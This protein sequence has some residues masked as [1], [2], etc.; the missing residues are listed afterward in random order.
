MV[1]SLSLLLKY[2]LMALG[3]TKNEELLSPYRSVC[4]MVH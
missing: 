4:T 3:Y 1:H 2:S